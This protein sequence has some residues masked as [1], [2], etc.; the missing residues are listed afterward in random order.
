MFNLTRSPNTEWRVRAQRPA[1]VVDPALLLSTPAALLL[2][3]QLSN[4]VDVWVCPALWRL[5]DS[6][7][8]HLRRPDRLARWLGLP[9]PWPAEQLAQAVNLCMQWR[10]SRDFTGLGV[11][12][13]GL[14]T[15]ESCLPEQGPRAAISRFGAL[16]RGWPAPAPA[17][18][19]GGNVDG[20]PN[21]D[22]T[23]ECAALSAA[24][25][26]APVLTLAATDGT[27]PPPLA[28][29]WAS[30]GLRCTSWPSGMAP[31]A[32]AEQTRWLEWLLHAGAAPTVATGLRLSVTHLVAPMAQFIE[33][34]STGANDGTASGWEGAQALWLNL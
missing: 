28:Q 10:N 23:R 16:L 27:A 26:G 8:F 21:H 12:W 32:Q 33:P 22:T 18:D 29:A 1:C 19:G 6:S 3:Q 4:V 13:V 9:E 11:Y 5:L 30:D 15:T 17:P 20:Q 31:H 25:Q 14:N 34:G 7:E 2:V 24:L